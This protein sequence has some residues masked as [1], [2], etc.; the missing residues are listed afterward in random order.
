MKFKISTLGCKVNQYESEV[1]AKKL[2]DNGFLPA[3]E[4][5][6][7]DI[8]I[9][10]SCTVTAESDR[11]VRQLLRRMKKDNPNSVS[12]LTGCMP[13]AF[14]DETA[15]SIDADIIVG[16]K[17][18]AGVVRHI[19][20]FLSSH[21]R[22]V[23][24]SPHKTGDAFEK[25]EISSF[26][27]RNRAFLKIQDGCN[28]FCSYCI[29]PYARGRSRSKPLNELY[30]EATALAAAGYREI[31]LTG[32]NLPSY[33]QDTGLS[34]CDAIERINTVDGIERI[35]LGSLEPEKLGKD[36]IRR[37]SEISKLCP[38]FHLALQ[39]GC[40]ETLKR[41]NRHYT[42]D[43]Y[44]R[45][46]HDLRESFPESAITTDIMVGFAGETEEEFEKSYAFAEEIGFAKMHVFMYSRRSG[47]EAYNMPG[48]IS[49]K[50]KAERSKRMLELSAKMQN[51]FFSKQIG[52]I[53][54]VLFE[55]EIDGTYEGYTPNYTPVRVPCDRD[56]CGKLLPAEIISAE[57][58]FCRAVLL[59]S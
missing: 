31:V 42:T 19:I 36:E 32:I 6:A 41:M 54:P 53:V 34:L 27:G 55:Q 37:V 2:E 14:P 30:D 59:P 47:T 13:Q 44:R 50:V 43:D 35:R 12:V 48:Q 28:R 38:Q 22:I 58:D 9:V 15:E 20:S 24:I 46:V 21:Q 40:D 56:I 49:N 4:N 7:A 51:E 52:K 1:I 18:R 16:T 11:K 33:G 3:D 45:I 5:E 29:I 10:N 8:I 57:E 17:N 25:M 26:S 23:D 39:S